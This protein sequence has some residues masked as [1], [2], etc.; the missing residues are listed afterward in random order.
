MGHGTVIN[1]FP[2]KSYKEIIKKW[3]VRILHAQLSHGIP[4]PCKCINSMQ[5][6]ACDHTH[7]VLLITKVNPYQNRILLKSKG[8]QHMGVFSRTESTL[9]YIE[10]KYDIRILMRCNIWETAVP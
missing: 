2:V 9:S 8:L 3:G 6:I 1:M 4:S 7:E 10:F 5:G